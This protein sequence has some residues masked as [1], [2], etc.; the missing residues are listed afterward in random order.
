MPEFKKAEIKNWVPC[1][2]P[3]HISVNIKELTINIYLHIRSNPD[4]IHTILAIV[5]LFYIYA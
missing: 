4:L 3:G 2:N 1:G 5:W